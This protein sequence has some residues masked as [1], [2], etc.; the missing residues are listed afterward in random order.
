MTPNRKLI[1][2]GLI[3]I[4]FEQSGC[5]GRLYH[6]P[7]LRDIM[8]WRTLS[9]FLMAVGVLMITTLVSRSRVVLTLSGEMN[10]QCDSDTCLNLLSEVERDQYSLCYNRTITMKSKKKFGAIIS[11]SC[12]FQNGSER[13]SVALGSF[14][15]SG[16]TW[17]RGLLE[18]LTGI[19]TGKQ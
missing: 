8:K 7:V 2:D 9:M 16:N 1:C 12:H 15:G 10:T 5:D 6:F 11:G 3:D 13:Y 18:K 17:L 14:Q 19:C 4:N